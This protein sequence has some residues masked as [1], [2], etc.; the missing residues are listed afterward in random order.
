MSTDI[1]RRYREA[2][3]QQPRL[4]R[5]SVVLLCYAP[6]MLLVPTMTSNIFQQEWHGCRKLWVWITSV[7]DRYHPTMWEVQLLYIPQSGTI[8]IIR[9]V[10]PPLDNALFTS[11]NIYQLQ[12]QSQIRILLDYSRAAWIPIR[13]EDMKINCWLTCSQWHA[14]RIRSQ[15]YAT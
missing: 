9:V 6:E 10:S 1:P 14:N 15:Q 5:P 2:V 13:K 12:F 3:Q 11:L 7:L 4:W 8:P